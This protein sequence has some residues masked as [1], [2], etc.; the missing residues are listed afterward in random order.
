MLSTDTPNLYDHEFQKCL[1]C[2]TGSI[3]GRNAKA[4]RNGIRL[5]ACISLEKNLLFNVT[6][7]GQNVINILCFHNIFTRVTS[8]FG[9][10]ELQNEEAQFQDNLKN[11]IIHHGI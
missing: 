11:S 10:S 5:F 4:L 6:K 8:S 7:L 2:S 1:S 3:S 9:D